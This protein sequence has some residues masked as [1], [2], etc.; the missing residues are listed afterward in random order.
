[1]KI[2]VVGTGYVGLVAGVCFAD[3]G[4]DVT[5][6]DTDQAKV[7]AL[8]RGEVP[9][10][11]PG[12]GSV[13][14]RAVDAGHLRF[15]TSHAEAVRDADIAFIAVGT[16]EGPD[17]APIMDY[18]DAAAKDTVRGAT[19]PL[20]LVMKSTVPV[21][22]AERVRHICAEHAQHAV[23]VVSNPEFLK[24]GDALADFLRP[25]RV[26]I[27]T[28]SDA[29]WE[30]MEALYRPFA[31]ASNPILRMSNVAAELTKYAS[32]AMLATRISFMNEIARLCDVVGADVRDVASGMGSDRRI[33][34]P[35]LY[36][37]CGYGGSCFPKD[38]QG[39]IH[40]AKA[41][42]VDMEIVSAAERVNDSQKAVILDKI[43]ARVGK[44]LAGKRVC[45]WGLSFKPQTDDVREAPAHV[46][47][48]GLLERGA[49]V[50]GCDPEGMENFGRVFGDRMSFVR[51]PYEAAQDA[52]VLVLLTEWNEFRGADF[53]RLAGVMRGREIFDGRN[54][55]DRD[56]AEAAGFAYDGIGLGLP[57]REV[58]EA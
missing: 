16:P 29:A 12:L 10:Y 43:D 42:G 8:E 7:E 58:A 40:V 21:G 18:V 19:G 32:N 6:V 36:A 47:V 1:M 22:T 38:T 57:A 37:G 24:E 53:G 30:K 17:G 2:A 26:V 50:I 14:R 56:A 55:L 4:N 48:G 41:A 46:V 44:E 54:V 35:F 9:I 27:G 52:D 3:A 25:D 31:R 5:C 20:I 51:D 23:E 33:G 49:E 15:T 45:V 39:L 11:E 13:M 28:D 34:K